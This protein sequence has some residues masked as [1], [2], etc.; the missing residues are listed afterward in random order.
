M[1]VGP[2]TQLDVS[3]RVRKDFRIGRRE[4]ATAKM[5][6]DNRK[7]VTIRDA[8]NVSSRFCPPGISL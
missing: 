6:T 1:E 2:S 8:F 5:I 3:L 7:F 4:V